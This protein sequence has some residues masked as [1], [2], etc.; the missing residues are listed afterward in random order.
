VGE[1]LTPA[2]FS[3]HRTSAGHGSG[4]AFAS[5]RFAK[6]S[7]Y[8]ELHFRHSLGLVVYRWGHGTISHADYLRGMNKTGA[9]PGYGADPLD[10]FRHLASDLAGPLC[11]FRDGDREGFERAR[12]IAAEA[13]ITKLP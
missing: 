5:G 4:G 7:Q 2:G 13:S 6:G 8:L 1:V 11:G 12:R 9:Y 3:F 10:G